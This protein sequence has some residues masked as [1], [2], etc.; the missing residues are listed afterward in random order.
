MDLRYPTD[1]I[2]AIA[3]PAGEGGIGVI[4][5]S[6]PLSREILKLIFKSRSNR[7]IYQS[8]RLY[9]GD[10]V[11]IDG[12][13]ILDEV[14]I[15]FMQ[16]P[17]SYTGEDTLEIYCHGGVLILRNALAEALRAGARLAEPGEFTKRAFLNGRLDLSQAEAVIRMITARTDEGLANALAH[18]KG[19]IAAKINSIRSSLINI[20]AQVEAEIDFPDDDI[21]ASLESESALPNTDKLLMEIR[22]ASSAIKQL[23]S[24]CKEGRAYHD[25]LTVV[26]VG[27]P[28]VGKSSLLNRL[29]QEETAIVTPIPGTTRDLIRANIAIQGVPFV[30]I[31]TAGIRDAKDLIEEKGISLV[32][33]KISEADIVL[34]MLD[35]SEPLSPRDIEI[36]RKIIASAAGIEMIP[37]VNKAD[38]LPGFDL[39]ELDQALPSSK[40]VYVSAKYGHGINALIDR[41]RS[42]VTG[43][44]S[45]GQQE[46]LI[47]SE[48]RHGLA[49]EKAASALDRAETCA[50]E[51]NSHELLSIE[52]REALVA[53]GEITGENAD[54]EVLER[55]F[56]RFCI[57]K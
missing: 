21:G 28:N 53:L 49:L 12:K 25:G 19:A 13:R 44:F 57:G 18:L 37:V 35:G 3:T 23:S 16:G 24:T 27:R 29:T 34:L 26:I 22:A 56:S 45:G 38:L 20:S 31:D 42:D 54:R 8:H 9:H 14:M 43:C 52:I 5:V 50:S 36:S 4:R 33:K 51:K 47:I 41:L 55:I 10:I 15:S 39:K 17:R 11:S 7:T 30:L 46:S 2:A 48:L 32:W 1:T 40:P 6:G